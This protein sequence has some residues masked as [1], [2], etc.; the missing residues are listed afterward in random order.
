MQKSH[1]RIYAK[2]TRANL[3]KNHARELFFVACDRMDWITKYANKN[4]TLRDLVLPMTHDSATASLNED[5]ISR[6]EFAYTEKGANQ[7]LLRTVIK[8]SFFRD[9]MCKIA[10]TQYSSVDFITSQLHMGVR[11]FDLRPYIGNT[12]IEEIRYQH[13]MVVWDVSVLGSLRN[14]YN[15]FVCNPLTAAEPFILRFSHLAGREACN[16]VVIGDFLRAVQSIFGRFLCL[17]ARDTDRSD[18]H[19][20]AL[21]HLQATPVIFILD[22]PVGA[23]GAI[24]GSQMRAAF[25]WLH[26]SAEVYTDDYR[27]VVAEGV[28]MDLTEVI[29]YLRKSALVAA[30]PAKLKQLQLHLQM[31]TP[32]ISDLISHPSRAISIRE[33][34]EKGR[35]NRTLLA[36]LQKLYGAP[37]I[38][39]VSFDFYTADMI[40]QI[41]R[42]SRACT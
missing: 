31:E 40:P 30:P 5:N 9:L 10:T 6:R 28:G 32:D 7:K 8:L 42:L 34:T 1:A 33:A 14:V 38:N 36:E 21:R 39:I 41:Y 27:A 19:L 35:V 25:P 29:G 22:V 3:C 15:N 13:G 2:I 18:F 37:G 23:A 17:R 16:P 11:V 24:M 26:I 20:R 4:A 12:K